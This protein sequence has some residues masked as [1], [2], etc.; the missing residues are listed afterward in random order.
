MAKKNL[1]KRL[2][3]LS[4]PTGKPQWAQA[5]GSLVL[6]ILA[7][8]ISFYLGL[9]KGIQVILI[10][11]LIA[12]I[13]MDI[14]L[15]LRKIIPLALL[16]FFMSIL[17]FTTASLGL[18]SIPLFILF[19]VLWSFFAMSTYIFGE[20]V[21]F[22]GFIVFTVY[23][24]AVIMV[25]DKSTALEWISYCA[26]SFTIASLLLLP[27]LWNR[28]KEIRQ[29]VAVG[30]VPGTPLKTVLNIRR[31]LSGIPMDHHYYELFRLGSYITGFRGYS[32]QI[33]KR[34]SGE[35]QEKFK[36]YLETADQA[37]SQIAEAI[38]NRRNQVDIQDLNKVLS[39]PDVDKNYKNE[40]ISAFIDVAFKIGD[41]IN[42]SA[43]IIKKP[44]SGDKKK[45]ISSH[46]SIKDVLTANFNL[47]N[48]YIR[49]ALRFTLAMTIGLLLVHLTHDR[50]VIWVT[51]G[52]LII[53]KP[54][55]TS[56]VNNMVMRVFFNILAIILA[57]ILGFLFPHDI[58]LALAFVMLFLFRAFLPTYMGLSVMALTI[59]V[60]FIWPT[61]TVFDNAIA[62]LVDITL[63][64]L[65]AIICA[66]IILPS[67]VKVDL[68]GQLA[69]T[70]RANQGYLEKVLAK[71]ES[72]DHKIVVRGLNNYLLEENNLEAAIRKLEDFFTDIGEDIIQ[73][74]EFLAANRKLSSDISALA[75]FIEN[76]NGNI[77][78]ISLN[79]EQLL[80][81]MNKLDKIINEGLKPSKT[82]IDK[83]FADYDNSFVLNNL[84]QYL[85]WVL[86]DIELLEE[87]TL[88]AA[89][90][91]LFKKYRDLS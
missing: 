82:Y 56:T 70:I 62:R 55:I 43:D 73:Y 78:D 37:S 75:A 18:S 58:L 6:M 27:R 22:F 17:A 77:S 51:M 19:T 76:E 46:T 39:S 35:Y 9:D 40:D 79:K 74:H 64:A 65:I 59:F 45:I 12:T 14:S 83:Y 53:I 63:G 2:R 41:L 81:V 28:K 15:P 4:R 48:M 29:M 88:K 87:L 24:I 50:D 60:V 25:N 89:E 10:T 26:L 30:F 11:T 86:S 61:G 33:L 66:Y 13:I 5:V 68:P 3:V 1:L 34:L 7:G 71:P 21:G 31:A 90:D 84:K 67:R 16:G 80:I 42:K 52:I 23:F 49:H 36:D 20:S 38:T 72:Y 85:E 44:L 54:D 57:I 69:G 8:L 32:K 47:K 91:G